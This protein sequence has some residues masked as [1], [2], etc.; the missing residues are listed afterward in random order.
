[1]LNRWMRFITSVASMLIL[2]AL[3]VPV[4]LSWL[5]LV[6]V[7]LVGLLALTTALLWDKTRRAQ[8]ITQV[9]DSLEAEASPV[10][11]LHCAVSPK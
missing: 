1:M 2:W 9:L 11:P 3:I 5:V 7:G 8:S 10:D 4:G 6:G